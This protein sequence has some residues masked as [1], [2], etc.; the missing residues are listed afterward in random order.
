M[1]EKYY[2]LYNGKLGPRIYEAEKL[3]DEEHC[4]LLDVLNDHG[5]VEGW[6]WHVFDGYEPVDAIPEHA[7]CTNGSFEISKL[8]DKKFVIIKGEIVMPEQRILGMVAKW[9]WGMEGE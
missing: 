8:W 5:E 4:G 2:L 3:R 7:R 9:E 1:T 6:R